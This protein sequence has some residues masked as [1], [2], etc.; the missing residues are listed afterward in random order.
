MSRML[1]A[2]RRGGD[3][4]RVPL[5]STR[6]GEE[7]QADSVLAALGY[8]DDSRR[9][10]QRRRTL[11]IAGSVIVAV[12]GVGVV[13]LVNWFPFP[14]GSVAATPRRPV[15]QPT[16]ED[17]LRDRIQGKPL[18]TESPGPAPLLA[19]AN[20]VSSPP[21]VPPAAPPPV[22]VPVVAA[23]PRTIVSSAGAA[24]GMSRRMGSEGLREPRRADARRALFGKVD[25]LTPTWSGSRRRGEPAA[26]SGG[27]GASRGGA[28]G[29]PRLEARAAMASAALPT[30]SGIPST[31]AATAVAAGTDHF[32]LAVYYQ[33]AGDID[34]ALVHYRALL[35]LNELNTEAHNNLGLLYQQK[36]LREDAMREFQRAILIEPKYAK[37]HNN[38]GVVLLQMGNADAAA[39]EFQSVL[40]TDPKDLDAMVNLALAQKAMGQV[41]RAQETL[42]QAVGAQPNNAAAHYNLALL[43]E[44]TREFARAI[45]HY[46]AFL[47]HA[48]LEH[49]GLVGEVRRR[50]DS[51]TGKLP[52]S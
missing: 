4:A 7:S 19:E 16:A 31:P 12:L 32:R 44:G 18:P 22:A 2:L 13:A 37:A 35:E 45:E 24:S 6:D 51:L 25:R 27:G 33:R 47:T 9:L 50:V 41:A 21:E 17:S 11:M 52:H 3:D 39:K 8:S 49:A 30:P 34:N 46:R 5:Q 42:L 1:D 43:Y 38:L 23:T 14:G 48:G 20:P 10:R 29:V 40:A 26:R 28:D 36:G 15:N